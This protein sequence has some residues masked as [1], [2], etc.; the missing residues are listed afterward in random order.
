MELRLPILLQEAPLRVFRLDWRPLSS[1][2]LVFEGMQL[3]H[4]MHQ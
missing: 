2:S 1:E 4:A 3:I